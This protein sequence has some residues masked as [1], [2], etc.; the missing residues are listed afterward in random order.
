MCCFEP[1]GGGKSIAQG[2]QSAALGRMA[3]TTGALKE[4]NKTLDIS[5][6][7]DITPFQGFV[8]K[9]HEDPGRHCVCPGLSHGGPLVLTQV[10]HPAPIMPYGLSEQY[11][12][13]RPRSVK[14]GSGLIPC[15]PRQEISLEGL[16]GKTFRALVPPEGGTPGQ[17]HF[18]PTALGRV[19]Q[20]HSLTKGVRIQAF[21]L[22]GVKTMRE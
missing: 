3:N 1:Q 17:R 19:S 6:M 5:D 18:Q 2:K 21:S 8:L 15:H 12:A 20:A 22:S 9:S 13:G 16:W 10:N 4:R 7:F 11:L 14:V